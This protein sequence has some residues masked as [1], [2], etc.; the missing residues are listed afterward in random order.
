MQKFAPVTH[1]QGHHYQHGGKHRQWNE[2]GERCG[3][4]H[5]QKQD[6]SVNHACYRGFPSAADVGR[7]A[8]DCSGS[9]NASKKRNYKV[10]DAL[11]HEFLVGVVLIVNHAVRA[12]Q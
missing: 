7:G 8:C 10:R 6:N 5:D 11:R 9:G 3:N 2:F 4:Q 12:K 1:I